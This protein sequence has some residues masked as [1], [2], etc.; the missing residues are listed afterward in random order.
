MPLGPDE[1]LLAGNNLFVTFTPDSP[2][3]PIAGLG[4]QAAGRFDK[5]G[6]WVTTHFLGGDDSVF[7]SAPP[8]G[9]S[10]SV[11]RLEF[12]EHAIQKVKLYRYR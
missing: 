2:G 10:G 7:S 1:Y 3:P 4:E 5:N 8:P 12:G 9:Q 11:V 6:K